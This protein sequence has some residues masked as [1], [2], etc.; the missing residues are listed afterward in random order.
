MVI[1]QEGVPTL[2]LRVLNINEKWEGALNE[3]WSFPVGLFI[4]LML[5]HSWATWVKKGKHQVISLE[6]WQTHVKFQQWGETPEPLWLTSVQPTA[7]YA[8][9]SNLR[10]TNFFR[11]KKSLDFRKP[12]NPAG[13]VITVKW[14][15]INYHLRTIWW[16]WVKISGCQRL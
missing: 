10:Q 7:N 4:R 16:L 2:G 5:L 9:V 13:W 12:Y 6:D 3:S 8:G 15:V 1:K 11:K 14:G